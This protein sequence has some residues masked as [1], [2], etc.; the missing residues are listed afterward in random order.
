ME[1]WVVPTTYQDSLTLYLHKVRFQVVI[2]LHQQ[3]IALVPRELR[4]TGWV[5]GLMWPLTPHPALLREDHAI[6]PWPQA[7][8]DASLFSSEPW[9]HCSVEYLLHLPPRL[10][11]PG[12]RFTSIPFTLTL[13]Q[14]LALCLSFTNA[15]LRWSARECFKTPTTKTS[16]CR[17][18]HFFNLL[19][20]NKMDIFHPRSSNDRFA[21]QS[22]SR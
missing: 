22:C 4:N 21:L 12:D 17:S 18:G 6:P 2:I 20:F 13:S 19:N 15:V 11:G 3:W 8:S 14:H 9:A 16:V 10:Q 1:L 5:L 7:E